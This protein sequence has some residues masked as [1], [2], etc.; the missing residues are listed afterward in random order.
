M[1]MSVEQLTMIMTEYGYEAG[2]AFLEELLQTG[3]AE[4]TE[5]Q[6]EQE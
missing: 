4:W 1:D 6:L 5:D 3:V 2:R